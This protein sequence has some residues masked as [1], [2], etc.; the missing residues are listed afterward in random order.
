MFLR[1]GISSGHTKRLAVILDRMFLRVENREAACTRSHD[2]QGKDD[3]YQNARGKFAE[4][5][6]MLRTSVVVWNRTKRTRGQNWTMG[7]GGL[8]L[9]LAGVDL[10]PVA[11]K[12]ERVL[13]SRSRYGNLSPDR[14]DFGV[15][16]ASIGK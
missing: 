7:R 3:G 12:E 2:R 13:P 4:S 10:R 6:M 9:A 5:N 14:L 8:Q 16:S 1:K 15:E 11:G